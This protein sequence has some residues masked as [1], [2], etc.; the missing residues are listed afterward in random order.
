MRYDLILAAGGRYNG[1]KSYESAAEQAHFEECWAWVQHLKPVSSMKKL[2][3]VTL[4]ITEAEATRLEKDPRVLSIAKARIVKANSV[5]LDAS[6]NLTILSDSQVN[7][8]EYANTGKGVICYIVDTGFTGTHDEFGDRFEMIYD[9]F[10]GV[11]IVDIHGITVGSVAGGKKYGV[12][13][14]VTL[15]NV[16]V[17][18]A[19]DQE[20]QVSY[21]A[22]GIDFIL[23]NHPANVP[24]IINLSLGYYAEEAEPYYLDDIAVLS[25]ITDGFIVIAAAGNFGETAST[26]R[27]ASL[28]GVICASAINEA[29]E[30]PDWANYGPEVDI[31]A[32]GELVHAY[33]Y[34]GFTYVSGT[35]YSAPHISGIAA[36]YLERRADATQ[37]EV[38][39]EIM[40][41]SYKALAT[42]QTIRA[43][44]TADVCKSNIKPRLQL[45]EGVSIATLVGAY[46]GKDLVIKPYTIVD[47][48]IKYTGEIHVKKSTVVHAAGSYS[49]QA[50]SI[51]ATRLHAK[52]LV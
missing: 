21:I 28:P 1:Y 18:P 6:W 26:Y 19:S 36:M 13:K 4:D 42:Q 25:A 29:V 30:L 15:K 43:D 7:T 14:E 48:Q 33:G 27:P 47:G 2:G 51:F 10:P 24:G 37:E 16:R 23:A 8:Y 49:Q 32:P 46:R 22:A 44:T 11:P 9:A 39:R 45:D 31:L 34:E 20:D 41:Q 3:S 52:E 35:S 38:R 5:Q 50:T 40:Q 17:L 12:A